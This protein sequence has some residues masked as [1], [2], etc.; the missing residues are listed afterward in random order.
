MTR[1]LINRRK[2]DITTTNQDGGK[3]TVARDRVNIGVSVNTDLWRR[4][5]ALAITQGALTGE[6]LDEAIESYLKNHTK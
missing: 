1:E 4:L 5:R 6:L 2:R 3:E